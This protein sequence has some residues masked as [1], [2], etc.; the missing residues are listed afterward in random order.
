MNKNT[1]IKFIQICLLITTFLVGSIAS[2]GQYTS[3][4]GKFQV[5][6]IRGCV[7]FT[8]KITTT[9]L[10]TT[11]ECTTSKPCNFDYG[12][13]KGQQQGQVPSDFVFT[14]TTAGTFKLSVVYQSA[15]ADDI[16]ITVDPDVKPE[17]EIYSCNASKVS[18]KVTD[19][20]YDQYLIDFDNNGTVDKTVPSG[21]NVIPQ[22]DYGTPGNYNLSVKGKKNNSAANCSAMVKPFTALV[23]LPS[24]ELDALSSIDKNNL[25]IDFSPTNNIQYKLEIAQNGNSSFQ[26]LQTLYATNTYSTTAVDLDKNY[27]CFRLG[28]YDACTGVNSYS[29]TAC[30]QIVNLDVKSG[31]N[32]VAWS[33]SPTGVSTVSI[34]RNSK[35]YAGVPYTPSSYQDAF[36]NINC[37]TN[38]SYYVVFNYTSGTKSTS[39]EKSGKSFLS[40]TPNAI[41]NLSTVTEG[42]SLTLTWLSDTTQDPLLT[43]NTY[44]ILKSINKAP[45]AAVTS[46][47]K[48]LT[49]RDDAYDA[50]KNGCYKINYTDACLNTSAEG[51]EAC[52]ILLQGTI[53]KNNAITLAW[54]A[55]SG[56][57]T[58]VKTYQVDKFSK[59]G[60]LLNST[61]VVA[62]NFTDDQA[63]LVNQTVS[64]K[65][66][67]IANDGAVL[68]S[69]SNLITLI[70]EANLFFPNVF[71]PNGDGVN[72]TFTV[73][74]QFIDKMD[75]K[76]YDRWGG[77][78]YSTEKNEPWTGYLNGK[79]LNEGSYIWKA[80]VTDYSGLTFSHTG[81]IFLL[82]KGK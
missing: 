18:I 81:T 78:L 45:Y 44:T 74:G 47:S 8:V 31:T 6:E 62:T 65:I 20:T 42:Q 37:N 27:Y 25:K 63:D 41:S 5:E 73:Y 40:V 72:D 52:P 70:K 79:L 49:Y 4:L 82:T 10:V 3:R 9:N 33:S 14:Y 17:F 48:P 57:Q 24:K 75:L 15:T 36:P 60:T 16:T 58:G 29:S 80:I 56:W 69:T 19:K 55:Y 54:N 23:A 38:Y 61:K 34:Y 22:F 26:Q 51:I 39:L 67:A 30:T 43:P 66:T 53:T 35:S 12:S 1:Q 11:G 21:N 32:T 13:G 68:S 77:L 46:Q 76:V 59:D 50:Q 2:F 64:Y 71:T 7:P 28:T